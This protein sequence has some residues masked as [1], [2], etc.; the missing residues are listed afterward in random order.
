MLEEVWRKGKPYSLLV[1]LQT[2]L[3]PMDTSVNNSKK[4]KKTILLLGICPKTSTFYSTD[5]CSIMFN[6]ALLT[7]A[8]K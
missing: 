6:A 4:K 5:I 3:A 7:I 8:R 2:V 1:G